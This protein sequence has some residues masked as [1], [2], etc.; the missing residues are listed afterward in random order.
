MKKVLIAGGSGLI[1]S[2]LEQKLKDRGFQVLIATRNPRK[3][4]HVFWDPL[5]GKMDFEKVHDISILINLTGDSI[6]K[7]RWTEK[8]KKEI[9]DSRVE[10]TNFLVSNLT[11]FPQLEHYFS[12]SGATCYGFRDKGFPYAEED[13]FGSDFLS[14]LT[15]RWEESVHQI[16]DKIPYT[17]IRFGVVL[18]VKGGGL[19]AITG[20]I[21]KGYGAIVG[22]GYQIM[23]WIHI[24]DLTDLFVFLIENKL[25]GTYQAVGGNNSNS[26][27][28][29][30]LAKRLGRKIWLPKVPA[31]VMKLLYGELAEIMI[32][33]VPS[34]NEKIISTGFKLK[35]TEL[36]YTLDNLFG[37]EYGFEES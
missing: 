20:P 21:K 1:G 22:S 9:I 3:D 17:I 18:T 16:K 7:S 26:E 36:D 15:K 8:R 32:N 12:A 19:S 13:T 28:T 30:A 34:S 5:N 2:H 6:G 23:P 14:Q 37:E 27:I 35:Y 31:F 10:S 33:G 24:D 11:E 25:T 29:K 4:S